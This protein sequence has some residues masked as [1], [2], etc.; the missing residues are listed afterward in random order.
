MGL[1]TSLFVR[2]YA[3]RCFHYD[4]AFTKAKREVPFTECNIICGP[5]IINPI[6]LLKSFGTAL[7]KLLFM[8]K[9]V[10]YYFWLYCT[11]RLL[12]VR[13]HRHIQLQYHDMYVYGKIISYCDL[14]CYWRQSV[15]LFGA[16]QKQGR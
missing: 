9:Y 5:A 7:T 14:T 10:M 6:F 16:L 12:L 2:L 15:G 11:I 1:P 4:D 8:L 13:R 3:T